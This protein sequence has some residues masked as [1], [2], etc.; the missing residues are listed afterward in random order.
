MGRHDER[1]TERSRRDIKP[2]ERIS[3]PEL[4]HIAKFR[5]LDPPRAVLED[6]VCP[7]CG[8]EDSAD[9]HRR[10]SDNKMRLFCDCCGAFITIVLTDEQVLAIHR[11]T[12]AGSPLRPNP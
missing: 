11:V 3:V 5:P 12:A 4:C 9:A 10:I 7:A 2:Q 8:H 6:L 1:R